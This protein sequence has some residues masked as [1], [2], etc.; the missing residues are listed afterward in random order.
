MT[1][2]PGLPETLPPIML[3]PPPL[4]LPLPRR[5]NCCVLCSYLV[6]VLRV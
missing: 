6:Q 3:L 1:D 4:P 2:L 5:R